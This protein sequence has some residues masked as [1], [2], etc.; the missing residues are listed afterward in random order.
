MHRYTPVL[1]SL[2]RHLTPTSLEWWQWSKVLDVDR[3][4]S[5]TWGSVPTQCSTVIGP[6]P[7]ETLYNVVAPKAMSSETNTYVMMFDVTLYRTIMNL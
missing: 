6:V 5:M 3:E 7:A 2:V 1:G 4:Q